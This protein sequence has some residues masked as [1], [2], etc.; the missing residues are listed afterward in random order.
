MSRLRTGL[1]QCAWCGEDVPAYQSTS[2]DGQTYCCRECEDECQLE[3]LRDR[4]RAVG[5]TVPAG[6]HV[7]RSDRR[8]S[9]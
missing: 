5:G 2:W 4:I 7:R 6:R 8:M 9:V 1:R 3:E